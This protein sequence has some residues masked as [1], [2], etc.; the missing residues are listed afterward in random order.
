MA[1]MVK[2]ASLLPLA[3]LL[4]VFAGCD[5]AVQARYQPTTVDEAFGPFSRIYGVDEQVY[6]LPAPP[7]AIGEIETRPR[8]CRPPGV[9]FKPMPMVATHEPVTSLHRNEPTLMAGWQE[10]PLSSPPPPKPIPIAAWKF[11]EPVGAREP[12]RTPP[13]SPTLEP[14]RSIYLNQP[15]AVGAYRRDIYSWCDEAANQ[16]Y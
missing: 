4:A 16:R 12:I 2:P 8:P 6:E 9:L 10:P 7:P 1:G 5:P 11:D 15:I 13:F 3:A 14:G